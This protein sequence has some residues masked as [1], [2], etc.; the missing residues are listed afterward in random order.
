M[1]LFELQFNPGVDKQTTPVG[2]IN[3]WINSDN[4]RF[5]YGLPEKVGGWQS[6]LTDTICGVARQQH[7]FVD[8][9]G[10]RYVAIGT[11]KFL[12]IYFEGQLHDITPFKS[13][14]AGALT[15]FT[16]N[17]I[18]TNNSNKNATFTTTTNH[19]LSVGDML[20]LTSVTAA[21]N[22]STT[23]A[24][25]DGFLYQVQS[26]P[27]P[28]TFILTLTQQE[29]NAGA[30]IPGSASG[31]V[32]PYDIVGPANQ[33]YGYGFGVGNFGGTVS[34]ALL[35][36]LDGAL[37]ANTAGNNGSATQIRLTS[38]TGFPA[39][40]TIAVG[41]ELITYASIAV[42]ELVGITRGAFGTATTG[43]SNGQVHND[44]AIV[45]NAT[46]F[47]G[48]GEAVEA[49]TVTLEPGLWSLSN[50]GQVLV[51]T[52]ANGKTF[53][54]NAGISARLST[55]ASTTTSGFETAI[56]TG[57]GNPTAS[58]LTLI[59]PTTRH[60]IHFGTETDIGDT[61]T[62]DNMFIR[63]SD[64]E[65]INRYTIE[66]TNTAGSQRLQDG[67]KIIGS[68]V[69]KENILV[70]TDNALYTMK[71]VGAPFTFGF[72]Q[73][74]TNCG[75]IGKNAAIEIDGVAYWMSNNGFFAFDGTSNSLSCS[76]E[77]FV[78]DDF[79]T[80]KGQQVY[81]GINNLYTEVVWY[82]PTQGSTFNNRYVVHNYGEGGDIPMGNWYTG[83]NPNAI[84]TTWLDS[85]IYPRPY[86]TAFNSTS[87]G[88][89]PAIQGSTGLGQ[90]VYFEHETG[91]DQV[92]PNGTTTI[93]TSLLESYNFAINTQEGTGE[94]M[95]AMRRFLPDFKT[96]S[97]SIDVT[98]AVSDY[99]QTTISA[100]DLSPFVITS[101]T[102]KVDTRARGRYASIK[103]E[104]KNSG[105]SWRF[106]TFRADVQ[107]DGRR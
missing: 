64:Q 105:D 44:G 52:I 18:V 75:L 14:N 29:T 26:V 12:L 79:D 38:T 65:G 36:D 27:T 90:T 68:I 48:W 37:A 8:L 10:N 104:N 71:F 4:V 21:T 50:F 40:G 69:A 42:N 13:N 43:T 34:S 93:L 31:T 25:Y 45:T 77:D 78:Y 35:N 106:G 54:W 82:Y 70:W 23:A 81:A 66:A 1:S 22:S 15:T 47:S 97:G 72:E 17:S 84:R 73:V 19:G 60:L 107:P 53:T 92:N 83:V 58:R 80:T 55:H 11:D 51:A 24:G 57:V 30:V 100:T 20:T 89:F 63:F 46:D 87:T 95:L 41:N 9:Q 6:L 91:T 62:Q 33:T 101:A 5:R 102:T 74:G 88:T 86:A 28:T 56:A 39:S 96:I 98:V 3:R 59:S 99:P 85:L 16:I 32:N 7:A 94:F 2:A 61:S 103:I 76:V 67:T 49:S